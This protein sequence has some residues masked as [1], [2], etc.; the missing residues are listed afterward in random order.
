MQKP[1]LQDT[2]QKLD[3]I[4]KD[5]HATYDL[6][7]GINHLCEN[8]LPSNKRIIETLKKIIQIIYPGF[9]GYEC[10]FKSNLEYWSGFQLDEIFRTLILQV[11][12]IGGHLAPPR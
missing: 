8:Q 4:L 10:V 7:D 2:K 6:E 3:R 5:I 11:D 12:T 1:I 9:F